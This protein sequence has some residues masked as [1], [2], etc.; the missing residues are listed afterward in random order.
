MK[1][2]K[3]KNCDKLWTRGQNLYNENHILRRLCWIWF[4]GDYLYIKQSIEFSKKNIFK[5]NN[6]LEKK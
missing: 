2:N 3:N 4:E 5:D 6:N 1:Q